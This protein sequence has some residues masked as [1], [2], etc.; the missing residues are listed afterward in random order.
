MTVS[1]PGFGAMLLN[2]PA[3]AVL[4]AVLLVIG[5]ALQLDGPAQ[6]WAAEWHCPGMDMVVG[7]LNPIGSGVTLL[8]VCLAL[9]LLGW[10]CARSRICQAGCVGALTFIVAGLV[11]YALKYLVGRPRPAAAGPLFGLELDSFPSG[12]ATSVFAVATVLG[13]VYPRLRWPLY[14][15]AA[16]IALGRVYLARHY[17]SD[18]VAGAL[19]GLVI[20]S[21]LLR[22]RSLTPPVTVQPS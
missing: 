4:G 1:P 20:A 2:R 15:L 8:I 16:A 10:T 22:H 14:T 19:I 18:I 9:A 5:T 12:H 7:W 13:A 21:L 3:A 17:L 11:E 6:R